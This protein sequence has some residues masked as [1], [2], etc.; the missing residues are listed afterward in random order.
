MLGSMLMLGLFMNVYAQPFAIL[1]FVSQTYRRRLA[2]LL[3][4]APA[5]VAEKCEEPRAETLS[6]GAE[7]PAPR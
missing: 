6:P 7:D 3:G 1:A 4:L 2:S 5:T